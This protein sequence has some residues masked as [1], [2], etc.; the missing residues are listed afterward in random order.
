MIKPE[1]LIGAWCLKQWFIQYEDGRTRYPFG[2]DA[3]GQLLYTHDGQ[4]SAIIM[5]PGR[6]GFAQN[7]PRL[8]TE[9]QKAAAFDSYFQYAGSWHIKGDVVVHRVE[10]ALNPDFVGT[11]QRRHVS[12]PGSGRLILS[13]AEEATGK[14]TR[15]HTLNWYKKDG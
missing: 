6:P 1:G 8:V 13:A 12:F 7:S 10:F 2:T 9:N 14:G 4:M 11:L 15:Y 3:V 5:G